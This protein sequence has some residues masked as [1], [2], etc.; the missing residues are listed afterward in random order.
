MPNPTLIVHGGAGWIQD[1]VWPDYQRGT[2]AAARAGQAVLESGGSALDA[3]CAACVA[4]ENDQCFN[5]GYGSSLNAEGRI[6]NDAF[7]MTD[8]LRVGAVGCLVG[9]RNPILAA[10]LVMEQT[11]HCLIVG[12]GAHALAERHGLALCDWR[13]LNV[14]RRKR[15]W[16]QLKAQGRSYGESLVLE[17]MEEQPAGGS[18]G[19]GGVTPSGGGFSRRVDTHQTATEVAATVTDSEPRDTIGALALDSRGG[20][21]AALSTGGVMLKLPGRIGDTPVPGSGAYCGPAG[22]VCATGHGEAAMRVCLAKFIYDLLEAGADAL[23]AAQAGV[24]YMVERVDGKAGVIVLDRLGRRA[25][26]TST[27]RISAGI[28]ERLLADAPSGRV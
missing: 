25:W 11:E 27:A 2:Q 16:E 4:L 19:G 18:D 15:Q 3:V 20:M 21:A 7:V 5:A 14:E 9:V 17:S 6:E 28:P 26:A 23:S 10:R 8:D 1:S 22:A 13:E 12:A 24:D